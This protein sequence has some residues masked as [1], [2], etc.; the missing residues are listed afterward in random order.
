MYRNTAWLAM[1]ILSIIC[2]TGCGKSDGLERKASTPANGNAQTAATTE[3]TSIRATDTPEAACREFLDAVRTGNDEKA[4]LMLS[5]IARE[6]AA[7]LGRS[8]TPSASDTA[9]FSIGAVKLI[10]NDGAQVDSTWT[11]IDNVGQAHSDYATWVLR[12]EQQ[13]WRIAG[14]AATIFQGEPPLVL[15]FEDPDEVLKKQQWAREE[16]RRRMEKENSQARET[17]NPE[18]SMRR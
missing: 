10:D 9:K 15:N 8:I 18:N 5:S 7:A 16:I 3:A 2:I 4:S 11:D 13:G 14:V 6:K 1:A 12:K 17:E